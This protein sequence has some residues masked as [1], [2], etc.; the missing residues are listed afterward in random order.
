MLPELCR[1]FRLRRVPPRTAH[2]QH[3]GFRKPRHREQHPDFELHRRLKRDGRAALQDGTFQGSESAI[4]GVG[5]ATGNAQNPGW[6]PGWRRDEWKLLPMVNQTFH[7][8]PDMKWYIFT[9]VDAYVVWSTM[10]PYLSTL[11]STQPIYRGQYMAIGGDQII[12]GRAG[13]IVSNQAF[14]A[15]VAH[16]SSHKTELEQVTDRHWAG[17]AVLGGAFKDAGVPFADIWA[18]MQGDYPGWSTYL[19]LDGGSMVD[20]IAKAWCNPV[21][22][23]HHVTPDAVR[24]LWDAEQEWAARRDNKDV[25]EIFTLPQLIQSPPQD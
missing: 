3:T 14:Q 1:V 8:F 20:G 12:Y 18:F 23:F 9:E 19:P 7:D 11:D 21:A 17:D 2:P 4:N 25:F 24:D 15:V 16:Y 13:F 10:L 22:T 5:T 6:R